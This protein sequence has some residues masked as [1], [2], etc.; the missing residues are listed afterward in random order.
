MSKEYKV[1]VQERVNFRSGCF[2]EWRNVYEVSNSE[3]WDERVTGSWGKKATLDDLL[4][5][6]SEQANAR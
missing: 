3:L 4:D 2:N 1:R 6:V 5:E